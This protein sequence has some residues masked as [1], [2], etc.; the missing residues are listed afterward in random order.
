[1]DGLMYQLANLQLSVFI[2]RDVQRPGVIY[3][4]IRFTADYYP[5]PES[6]EYYN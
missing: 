6:T 5:T 1:M 4:L 2:S 3:R